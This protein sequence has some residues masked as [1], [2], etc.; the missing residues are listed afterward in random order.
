MSLPLMVEFQTTTFIRTMDCHLVIERLY[1]IINNLFIFIKFKNKIIVIT[2]HAEKQNNL[3]PMKK[4]EIL[5][6][7]E[8][9]IIKNDAQNSLIHNF[10]IA[11]SESRPSDI[12]T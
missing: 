7:T 5:A 6:L 2:G 9:Q 4:S 10:K 1:I 3:N 12:S 8:K 11:Q